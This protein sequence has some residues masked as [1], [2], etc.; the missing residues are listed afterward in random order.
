MGGKLLTIA[1]GLAFVLIGIGFARFGGPVIV[2]L[3]RDYARMPGRFQ[4]PA[5]RHRFM[6]AVILG[7][8]VLIAVVGFIAVKG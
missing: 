4:Y 3:N 1:I 7:F 2:A 8:G 6:G 5:M